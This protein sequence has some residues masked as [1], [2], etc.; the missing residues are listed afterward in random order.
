MRLVQGA[1]FRWP[2]A[3]SKFAFFN[4]HIDIYVTAR[5]SRG[6]TYLESNGVIA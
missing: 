5:Y 2:W 6:M 4:K 3:G 1:D